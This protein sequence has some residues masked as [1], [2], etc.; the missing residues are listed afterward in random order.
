M[1]AISNCGHREND[2]AV[3]YQKYTDQDLEK[4]TKREREIFTMRRKGLACWEVAGK[5]GIATES[6]H[7]SLS[8]SAKKM[9]GRFDKEREV[10]YQHQYQKGYYVENKEKII[11]RS[12]SY[13]R[14]HYYYQPKI[15]MGFKFLGFEVVNIEV[16]K[17]EKAR[18][19]KYLCRCKNC[20]AEIWM[21]TLKIRRIQ[22]KKETCPNCHRVIDDKKYCV[23]CGAE[24]SGRQTK[25]CSKKCMGLGK[26]NYKIC[27][28]C[29]KKFKDSATND[30][31]C[32]SPRCSKKHREML[33]ESGIYDSSI[34]KM[35]L[36]F[37][38]KVDEIGPEKHWL[39]KHWVIESPSGQ[40]YECDNLL[41]FIRENPELF[42][43]TAKQAF[44]GFQKMRA[45]MAGTRKNPSRSWKGW[46]LISFT[47]NNG[48]Y[49]KES[50]SE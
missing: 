10:K 29:G 19:A 21:D 45:T 33:H 26:Q 32:C 50:D 42:D 30:T 4:L 2:M 23:I 39:S 28:V 46:H 13:H 31:V 16:K 25:Y 18:R 22:R 11:N 37:S 40:V 8:K 34:E 41:N 24:L 14:N 17:T 1:L 20:G 12:K 6:V 47:D 5:L 36:G 49:Q 38:E 15:E 35:R 3:D 9:D 48:R 43:G 44:D 7:T 27:P